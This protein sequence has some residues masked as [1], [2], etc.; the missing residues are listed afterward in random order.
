MEYNGWTA[1]LEN[2][3]G[4]KKIKIC[5]IYNG[6]PGG[7]SYIEQQYELCK[8][9]TKQFEEFL[10]DGK[11]RTMPKEYIRHLTRWPFIS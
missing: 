2:V 8:D 6:N 11:Q 7:Y 4:G 10:Q 9:C 5:K 3:I 1:I